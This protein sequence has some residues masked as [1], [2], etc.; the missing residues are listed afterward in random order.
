MKDTLIII[1]CFPI[2]ALPQDEIHNAEDIQKCGGCDELMLAKQNLRD[3]YEASPDAKMICFHC[4]I[5]AKDILRKSGKKIEF[6]D[7]AT[8]GKKH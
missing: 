1:G 5:R 8:I 7:L 2:S 6:L 3:L 4:V